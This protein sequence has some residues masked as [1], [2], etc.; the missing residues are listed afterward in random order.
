[1]NTRYVW[2]RIGGI[3]VGSNSQL[4]KKG[5]KSSKEKLKMPLVLGIREHI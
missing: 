3:D 1:M 4:E 5:Q 2:F